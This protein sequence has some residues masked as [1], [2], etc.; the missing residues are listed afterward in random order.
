MK[1]LIFWLFCFLMSLP[2]L[3]QSRY[4]PE[5]DP[6]FEEFFAQFTLVDSV[7]FDAPGLIIG[8]ISHLAWFDNHAVIWDDRSDSMVAIGTDSKQWSVISLADKLP[9]NTWSPVAHFFHPDLGYWLATF[10]SYYIKLNPNGIETILNLQELPVD[11]KI[12]VSQDGHL[13]IIQNPSPQKSELVKVDI[14][15]QN[16][17]SRFIL[18]VPAEYQAF[19]YRATGYGGIAVDRNDRIYYANPVENR[20][21]C[22]NQSGQVI[23][24]LKSKHK[25]YKM[26]PK[27]NKLNSNPQAIL[28]YMLQTR[29]DMIA[30][31]RL[32]GSNLLV[33][34]S[35]DRRLYIELFDLESGESIF[36][37]A[38]KVPYVFR[39]TVGNRICLCKT[40]A[41]DTIEDPNA[42]PNPKI[43]VYR[44]G[45]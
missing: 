18:P 24:I 12:T 20:V 14:V 36:G 2:C 13:Y 45:Q 7:I 34:Y 44:Y 33:R 25:S 41:Y 10:P 23:D 31:I 42:I 11:G 21:Y 38:I 9:G 3:S 39:T 17:V 8:Q 5:T 29:P 30:D 26:M 27:N 35:I 28:Q 4:H 1:L 19:A 37:K 6:K 22:L 32:F 15:S 16:I 40:P 43:L